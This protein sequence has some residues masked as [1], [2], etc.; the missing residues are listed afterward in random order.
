MEN[1]LV[2]KLKGSVDNENLS[3]FDTISLRY[4]QRENPT[5]GTQWLQLGAA[6]GPVIVEALDGGTFSDTYGGESI[7]ST[8]TINSNTDR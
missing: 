7:G 2:T 8:F 6:N 1:C 3:F 4:V 5:D